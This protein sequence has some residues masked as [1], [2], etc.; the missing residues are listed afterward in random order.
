MFLG[1]LWH[2][3]T[4]SYAVSGTFHGLLLAAERLMGVEAR[5]AVQVEGVGFPTR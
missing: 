5:T 2:G 4:W 3:A 1:G